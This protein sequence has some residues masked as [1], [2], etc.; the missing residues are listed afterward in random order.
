MPADVEIPAPVRIIIFLNF[1]SLISS[2]KAAQVYP[3]SIFIWLID[4]P[5]FAMSE[6]NSPSDE[7]EDDDDDL[8]DDMSR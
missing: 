3:P 2:N 4:F 1:S 7:L 6:S 5:I 8:V